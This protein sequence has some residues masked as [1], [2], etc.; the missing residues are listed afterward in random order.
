MV[1]RDLAL[2]QHVANFIDCIDCLIPLQTVSMLSLPRA[3]SNF[4]D[5]MRRQVDLRKEGDNL[6]QFRSN[7]GCLESNHPYKI[8]DFPVPAE[9][10]VSEN[11]LVEAHIDAKPI[12]TFLA[13]DTREGLRIRKKLPGP[14]L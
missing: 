9:G 5:I 1:E 8:I 13:D 12:S 2:M 10:F 3:V 7:F 6:L 4:S 11:V 14:L